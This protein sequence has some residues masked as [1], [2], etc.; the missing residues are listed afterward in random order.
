MVA[1]VVVLSTPFRAQPPTPQV[2]ESTAAASRPYRDLPQPATT[3]T[4]A[5]PAPR[6]APRPPTTLYVPPLAKS[7]AAGKV[8]RGTPR[9]TVTA[10][11]TTTTVAPADPSKWVLPEGCDP[12]SKKPYALMVHCWDGLVRQWSWPNIAT[13]YRIMGC[14]SQGKANARGPPQVWV[15]RGKRTTVYPEGLMQVVNGGYDPHAN[16]SRTWEKSKQGRDW[17]PWECR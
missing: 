12:N 10:P 4:S 15:I 7:R 14:E 2:V 11:A 6:P 17:S 13:V 16:L 1:L 9:T 5:P 3:T 8:S